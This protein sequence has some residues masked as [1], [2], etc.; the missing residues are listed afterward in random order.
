MFKSVLISVILILPLTAG[1]RNLTLSDALGILDRKNLEI[2][3]SKFEE[4]MKKY[5]ELA[6]EGMNYGK[7][8]IELK[9]LRSNDAG[10]VFGFKLQSREADFGDF[11]FSDFLGPMGNVMELM[12]QYPGQLPPGFTRGMGSLLEV[13]PRDLNYPEARNHFVTTITYQLPVYTGGKLTAY[14]DITRKM[15]EMSLLDTRKLRNQKIYQVKKTFYDISLVNK[16]ISNLT[17]I[18]RNIEKLKRIIV[19]MKKEGY[20]KITD[21]YEVD[22]RLSQVL[23]MLNQAYLNRDLAY[24]FLSF[25]LDTEVSSIK[26]VSLN[27]PVPVIKKS[28]IERLSLDIVKAKTG[29]EISQL[30][31]DAEKANFL[32]TVGAFAQYGSADNILWNDFTKKDSYT[33]GVQVKWNI[34][35][36]GTDKANL[37]KARVN[38][39]KVSSQVELAKKGISLQVKKLQTAIKSLDY[40]IESHKKQLRL[41]KRVYKTYEEKYKEGLSSITDVL[42]KQARELEVLLGLL[43]VANERNAKVFELESI[44]DLGGNS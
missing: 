9:A 39:M 15:Y 32:P 36:G 31:I 5:E 10:N 19:E 40:D 25:L 16:Y 20:T 6:V 27:T 7:V 3:I 14:R 4:T 18:K 34:F 41:A 43:K 13:Q 28:D 37:E 35:N 42:I 11:G 30:A 21:I 29:R 24:Q 17:K 44:L 1:V 2:K 8:D 22:A 23:S 12:N 38:L 26:S 33:I